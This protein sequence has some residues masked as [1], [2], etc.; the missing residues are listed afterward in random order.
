[1]NTDKF[2]KDKNY[3]HTC[4]FC[5]AELKEIPG[6]HFVKN[7]MYGYECGQCSIPLVQTRSGKPFS[8]YNIGVMKDIQLEGH[9][10]IEQLIVEET[11]FIRY[12]DDQWFQVHNNLK[13]NQTLMVLT[14]PM[15]EADVIKYGEKPAGVVWLKDI[16]Y[17]P[18]IESWN[19]ADE[20][21]T[22]S[23]IKTYLL[24]L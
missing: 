23:K 19:P 21:A 13:K 22:L 9:P 12:K 10:V 8:R 17:L 14:R 16:V 5:T 2:I 1:M 6:T 20:E 4:P 11:F 15:E 24:F 7:D 3:K 18:F